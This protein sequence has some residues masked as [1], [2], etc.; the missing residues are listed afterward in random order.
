[1]SFI[2]DITNAIN[3]VE[4]TAEQV[5]AR[6]ATIGDWGTAGPTLDEHP[7]ITQVVPAPARLSG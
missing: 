7:P 4:A 5:A 6:L 1:M 3:F 2:D